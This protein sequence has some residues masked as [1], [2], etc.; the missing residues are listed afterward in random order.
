MATIKLNGVFENFIETEWDLNV[1]SI[2]EMFEAIEANSNKL[3]STL[4][5]LGEYITHFVVYLDGEIVPPEYINSP[6]LKKDSKIEVVPLIF[7]SGTLIMGIILMVVSM[8]IQMLITKMLTPKSPTDVKTVSRLFSGYEN[9]SMRNVVIPIGYGRVKISSIIIS[10]DVSFFY[11]G[12]DGFGSIG[13]QNRKGVSK[14]SE[15]GFYEIN[16]KTKGWI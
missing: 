10:N 1:L 11:S 7:G 15:L 12:F 6:I 16:Q 13:R 2:L 5:V 4:G 8:G 3:I 9:V 14:L